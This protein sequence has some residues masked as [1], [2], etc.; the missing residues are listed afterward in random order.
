MRQ[1]SRGHGNG[2]LK[3]V[4]I[5]LG[6][7]D[8]LA[9]AEAKVAASIAEIK[10]HGLDYVPTID[11]K[12]AKQESIAIMVATNRIRSLRKQGKT[13]QEIANITG[14]SLTA[15]FHR[16]KDISVESSFAGDRNPA[17]KLTEADIHKIR[18]LRADGA[19]LDS[20]AEQFG[21]SKPVIAKIAR[22]ELWTHVKTQWDAFLTA[23]AAKLA[24]SNTSSLTEDD[25]RQ[26]RKRYADGERVNDIA[27]HY[28]LTRNSIHSI[29]TRKTWRHVE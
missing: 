17:A 4:K 3:N 6:G 5:T 9:E 29:A 21:V 14:F 22:C 7:Y 27:A 2:D 18:R 12:K 13:M 28:G 10:Q 24:I 23:N 25:V 26:I 20:L 11:K 19:T 16:T 1:M 8:T 15:I